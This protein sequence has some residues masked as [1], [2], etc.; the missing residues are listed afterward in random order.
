[1]SSLFDFA[2]FPTIQTTRLVLREIVLDDRDD[3][4]AIRSD[5]AVTHHNIGAAYADPQQALDLIRSMRDGYTHHEELRWGIT[6]A[7]DATV[8]GMCGF[9]YLDHRDHRG[10]IGFD[11]NQTYWRRG[12]MT[13]AVAA[14]LDFGFNSL[15]FHRIEAD[16][17]ADNAASIALLHK[18]GFQ[19]EGRQRDQFLEDD[20]YHDLLLFSLLA[21]EWRG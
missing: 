6:L 7:P 20:T 11:L 16:A 13:E 19:D 9:N 8:I 17:S 5:F 21:N 18:L 12:I 1:M 4:F 2:E 15:G 14:M 3:I 10:S